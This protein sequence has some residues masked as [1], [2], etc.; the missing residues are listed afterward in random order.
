M[1]LALAGG[2]G[3][4]SALSTV[5]RALDPRSATGFPKVTSGFVLL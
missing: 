2:P 4:T 1:A 5:D 3:N